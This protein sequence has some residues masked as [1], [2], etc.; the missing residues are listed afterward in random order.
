MDIKQNQVHLGICP[1]VSKLWYLPCL[2]VINVKS[3]WG[4]RIQY[5]TI[6]VVDDVE[7]YSGIKVSHFT[8]YLVGDV[9]NVL[10]AKIPC[11]TP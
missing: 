7:A 8:P 1:V 2:S 3:F 5:Y 10:V 9:E 11:L 4:T 6:E